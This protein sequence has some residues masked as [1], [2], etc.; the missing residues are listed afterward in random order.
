M[1]KVIRQDQLHAFILLCQRSFPS[2]PPDDGD[3]NRRRQET[4]HSQI[5]S[6][7]RRYLHC[8][9][10]TTHLGRVKRKQIWG[11]Q[12]QGGEADMGQSASGKR[13]GRLPL[14]LV[15]WRQCTRRPSPLPPPSHWCLEGGTH[16][17]RRSDGH[18]VPELLVVRV[19]PPVGHGLHLLLHPLA[20][21]REDKG[22]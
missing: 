14:L 3:G 10:H 17:T 18:K 2:P 21:Y 8:K 7:S 1:R 9:H 20:V 12:P 19:Y 15:P 22:D 6:P 16:S 4:P 5:L 13:K 11:S